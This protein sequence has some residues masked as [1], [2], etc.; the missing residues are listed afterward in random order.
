MYATDG[1]QKQ[2]LKLISCTG[3]KTR[4]KDWK[5]TTFNRKFQSII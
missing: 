5:C 3:T 1:R 4:S 2:C